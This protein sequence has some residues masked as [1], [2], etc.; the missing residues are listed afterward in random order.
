M[1]KHFNENFEEL[2]IARLIRD[3]GFWSKYHSLIKEDY[4]ENQIRRDIFALTKDFYSKYADDT[5]TKEVLW[6]EIQKL[7]KS[8]KDKLREE[9]DKKNLD[10]IY[11]IDK[12]YAKDLSNENYTVEVLGE[13][14]Q[15]QEMKKIILNTHNDIEKG[16]EIEFNELFQKITEVQQI[17]SKD[18]PL[19]D[20]RIKCDDWNEHE[21]QKWIVEGLIPEGAI[22]ILYGKPGV[23]KSHIVW[24]MGNCIVAGQDFLGCSTTQGPVYYLDYEN[25]SSVV[26]HMKLICGGGQM[27]ILPLT[28]DKPAL[29]DDEFS[30]FESWPKGTWIIDTW[31][32]SIKKKLTLTG[33]DRVPLLRKLKRLCAKGHTVIILLHPLKHDDKVMKG[34]QEMAGHGD[35]LLLIYEIQRPGEIEEVGS[36]TENPNRPK[37]LY[38]GCGH[39]M[40]S[41]FEKRVIYLSYDPRVESSTRGLHLAANPGEETLLKIQELL[42]EHIEDLQIQFKNRKLEAGDYPNQSQFINLIMK[43][44]EIG[45]TKS[46]NWI[47]KGLSKYW[48]KDEIQKGRERH[49]YYFPFPRKK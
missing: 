9:D 20:Q 4:F 45:K 46:Q 24:K 28:V 44:L 48:G 39:D 40:K 33:E 37:Y 5:M 49:H 25:P 36:E 35:H 31:T 14:A 17:K 16:K 10:D 30:Q 32:M 7:L 3:K 11:A 23:G 12:Y 26:S 21:Y 15:R 27:D 38:F 47:E 6:I 43:K 2:L 34:P 42:I 8:R 1:E 19:Y 29:D 13:F 22:T 18:K 41:R